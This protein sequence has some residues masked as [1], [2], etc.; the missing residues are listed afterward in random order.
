[1]IDS[2]FSNL[3]ESQM[4]SLCDLISTANWE[5]LREPETGHI[6]TDNYLASNWDDVYVNPESLSVSEAEKGMRKITLPVLLLKSH[7]SKMAFILASENSPVYV[8]P[9]WEKDKIDG[10]TMI[11]EIK[12]LVYPE[13]FFYLS[14]YDTWT[15]ISK[16]ADQPNSYACELSFKDV[17]EFD[18]FSFI[19][20]EDIFRNATLCKSKKIPSRPVQEKQIGDAKVIER[21]ILDKMSEKERKFQQKEWLNE[22]HIRNSKHRLSNEIMPIHMAVERLEHFLVNS[23]EGIKLTSIIG[24]VTKQTVGDLL[25]NLKVSIQNIE[26]E[27]DNL[28]QSETVGEQIEVLDVALFIREYSEKLRTKF[29]HP[30]SIDIDVKDDNLKIKI[31]R[32]SFMELVDNVI[33]NAVRH[34]F[35]DIIRNDYKV[36]IRISRTT[37]GCRIDIANNGNPI[38]ERGRKEYFVRGSFAGDTGHTGIGG[39]RVYEICEKFNGKAIEP[40]PENEFPVVV[41]VIFPIV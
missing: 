27:I 2:L 16:S 17:G 39:A 11:F 24:H 30:F 29:S 33:S 13:Y 41:S 1:M 14:K 3:Q 28:T 20:A 8:A 32:K 22:T 19:S 5:E 21:V 37:E 18:G 36:L 25:Y 15:G 12:P 7:S 31:S 40:H 38:S 6:F 9:F 23:P 10:Y 34:G 4:N 35:T 26:N